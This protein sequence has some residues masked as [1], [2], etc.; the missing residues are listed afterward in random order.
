MLVRTRELHQ[1]QDEVVGLSTHETRSEFVRRGHE[2]YQGHSTELAATA[3]IAAVV[4]RMTYLTRATASD[5]TTIDP[6]AGNR[7]RT[8]L[9]IFA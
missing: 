7:S 3:T 8:T 1:R 6:R 4:R 2:E 9:R 5:V